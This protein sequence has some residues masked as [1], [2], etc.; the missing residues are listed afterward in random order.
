MSKLLH[1]QTYSRHSRHDFDLGIEEEGNP[2]NWHLSK[3]VK[4]ASSKFLS[5]VSSSP[6]KPVMY[7]LDDDHDAGLNLLDK[8]DLEPI[9]PT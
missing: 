7:I 6:R 9:V 4:V 8:K 1:R 5:L 2:R 3:I